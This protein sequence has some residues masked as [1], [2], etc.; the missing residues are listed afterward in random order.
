MTYI[1]D[2]GENAGIRT[3]TQFLERKLLN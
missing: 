1:N 3:A 2:V